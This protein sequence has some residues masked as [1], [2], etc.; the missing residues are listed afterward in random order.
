MD[1][2]VYTRIYIYTLKTKA[3][4]HMNIER[5]YTL[6]FGCSARNIKIYF[7][8]SPSKH[9]YVCVKWTIALYTFLTLYDI[10]I[11]VGYSASSW[12]KYKHTQ[13]IIC[14]VPK[15]CIWIHARHDTCK[16]KF[17]LVSCVCIRIRTTQLVYS[18]AY[19]RNF[20]AT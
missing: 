14:A 18:T 10:F 4:Y 20:H 8:L 17:T 12:I 15:K 1:V 6:L 19:L 13:C 2:C 7:G 11:Y 5:I 3:F 9:T 16:V